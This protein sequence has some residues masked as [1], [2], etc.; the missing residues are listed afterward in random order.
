[1]HGVM[2]MKIKVK[3]NGVTKAVAKLEGY[4]QSV[5]DRV[6]TQTKNSAFKVE[7]GAKKRCPV[8]TGRLRASLNTQFSDGGMEADIGTNVHYSKY[9]EFG[10]RKMRAQPYLFPAW[11][12][13]KNNYLASI[14]EILRG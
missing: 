12:E 8:D 14:R 2:E 9:V 13:E 4:E 7:A 6:T 1:M 3:V 10:T 5:I 11:A